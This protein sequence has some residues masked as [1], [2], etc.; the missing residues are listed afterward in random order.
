MVVWMIL[1]HTCRVISQKK[2][3][4][5]AISEMVPYS[6]R[7]RGGTCENLSMMS[8]WK[9]KRLLAPAVAWSSAAALITVFILA[10][11]VN[12]ND[13]GECIPLMFTGELLNSRYDNIQKIQI[14]TRIFMFGASHTHETTTREWSLAVK[15]LL[16][17]VG[18][19]EIQEGFFTAVVNETSR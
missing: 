19:G 13:G 17:A 5:G 8:F 4:G 14:Q 12:W 6:D 15:H 7:A 9:Y 18:G 11:G 3:I 16:H 1:L 10:N 2:Q